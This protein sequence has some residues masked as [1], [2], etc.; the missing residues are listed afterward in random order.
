MK[1]KMLLYF[2]WAFLLLSLTSFTWYVRAQQCDCPEWDETCR[3]KCEHYQSKEYEEYNNPEEK[4]WW[5]ASGKCVSREEC[6]WIALNTCFPIIWNCIDTWKEDTTN[7]TQA[8]PMMIWALTKFVMSL[9]LVVCFILIIV[10]WIMR[11]GDNPWSWKWWWAK[12]LLA[13]VA[14]TIL[15][16]WFSW[17]ILRLIN[18][19]F[20]WGWFI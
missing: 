9:V 3:A 2:L 1:N 8:F 5:K 6:K 14:I 19:N 18:P 10:A 4:K 15:L 13:K 12:W 16:L 17:V 7:P 20:F 11:A